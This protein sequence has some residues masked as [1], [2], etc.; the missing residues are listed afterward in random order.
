MQCSN[1][2]KSKALSTWRGT[3]QKAM[4]LH[5]GRVTQSRNRLQVQGGSV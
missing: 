5:V 3:G 4:E 1:M 2:V